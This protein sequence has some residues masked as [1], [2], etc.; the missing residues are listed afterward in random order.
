MQLVQYLKLD[1]ENENHIPVIIAKQADDL[2]RV[3]NVTMLHK[4]S[5]I[6]VPQTA[7]AFFRA[8]KPDGYGIYNYGV[9]ES[10]GTVTITLTAQTLAVVGLVKA[11]ITILENGEILSIA[12]FLIDVRGVPTGEDIESSNEFIALAGLVENAD[13][14]IKTSE[15]YMLAAEGYAKGTQSGEQVEDQSP[16]YEANAKYYKEQASQSAQ[17]AATSENNASNSAA[18]AS[19]SEQN[20]SN[21]ATNASQSEQNASN[22]ADSASQSAQNAATSENNAAESADNASQ[23]AQNAATSEN[24]AE[25]SENNAGTNALK[26]EGFAT[27]QQDGVDVTSGSDY[28]ENNAKYYKEQAEELVGDLATEETLSKIEG[29]TDSIV[30]LLEQIIEQGGS[31]S[32]LNGFSLDLGAGDEL[33]I[34][35]TNPEDE[36]DTVTITAVTDTTAQEIAAALGDMA[37]IW[38]EAAENGNN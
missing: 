21:S 30:A 20:A 5:Q 8:K 35:Y 27:G 31:S 18:S 23:S 36:E 32:D 29:E 34:T 33:L 3:I 6:I 22:S 17:N 15:T 9:I 11:D 4:K 12:T 1:V 26:S 24:N 19:Q 13:E 37:D 38:K 14:I 10:D 25:T 2:S 16:Y 7:T 28:Y